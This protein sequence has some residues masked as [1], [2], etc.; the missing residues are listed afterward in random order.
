[1]LFKTL[2]KYKL[3]LINTK[4]AYL[5]NFLNN[6]NVA[7]NLRNLAPY[8]DELRNRVILITEIELFRQAIN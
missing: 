2:P 1:M 5:H 7:W 8:P 6:S 3:A 4:T